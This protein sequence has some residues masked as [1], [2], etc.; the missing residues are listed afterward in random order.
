[1]PNP[2]QCENRAYC[3]LF[4]NGPINTCFNKTLNAT[5]PSCLSEPTTTPAAPLD[6]PSLSGGAIVGITLASIGLFTTGLVLIV[7]YNK[8][9]A[10]IFSKCP[11]CRHLG[12]QVLPDA[13]AQKPQ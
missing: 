1:M 10:E 9:I 4:Y 6:G 2:G 13:A 12:Y 5:V 8:K 3:N 7:R 11:C